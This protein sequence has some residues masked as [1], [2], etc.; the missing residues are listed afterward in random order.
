MP[1]AL[2]ANMLPAL[3]EDFAPAANAI[4]RPNDLTSRIHNCG[5]VYN[6][7]PTRPSLNPQ[8]NTCVRGQNPRWFRLRQDPARKRFWGSR[9]DV[10]N[11]IARVTRGGLTREYLQ[12]NP[13]PRAVSLLDPHFYP[14]GPALRRDAKDT[15]L[16]AHPDL[17]V[18]GFDDYFN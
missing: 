16:G 14:A 12:C 17:G 5:A 6:K 7:Y 4:D 9:E 3:N 1:R 15:R 2:A 13:D 11:G 10:W 18:P 8:M